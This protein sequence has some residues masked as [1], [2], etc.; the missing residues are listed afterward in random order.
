VLDTAGF[1][2][3]SQAAPENPVMLKNF[4]PEFAPYESRCRFQPC[5]HLRE[6][7]CAVLKARNDGL[8]AK[9]RVLRYHQLLENAKEVWKERYE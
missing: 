1:S 8:I 5:Y 6:P 9:E 7:G 4:Y 3:V 2:L